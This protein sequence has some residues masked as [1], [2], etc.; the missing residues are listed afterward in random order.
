MENNFGPI[1]TRDVILITELIPIITTEHEFV[2]IH[3]LHFH[4][5]QSHSWWIDWGAC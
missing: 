3:A 4:L 5:H 1:G 2:F